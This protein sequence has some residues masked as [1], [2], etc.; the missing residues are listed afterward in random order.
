M[1]VPNHMGQSMGQG[2]VM[3]P[4]P[5]LGVVT[6]WGSE[7]HESAQTKG[8]DTSVTQQL[9]QCLCSS[10]CRHQGATRAQLHYSDAFSLC[11]STPLRPPPLARVPLSEPV[12][13]EHHC[14]SSSRWGAGRTQRR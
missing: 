5:L 8:Q 13:E 9:L 7:N 1:K 11:L 10:A 12:S 14:L 3:L 4:R 2:S 6:T